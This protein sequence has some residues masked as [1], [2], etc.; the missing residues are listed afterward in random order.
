MHPVTTNRLLTQ[1][2]DTKTKS[3]F[4]SL[5][6]AERSGPAIW[7][8]ITRGK[9]PIITLESSQGAPPHSDRSETVKGHSGFS[10]TSV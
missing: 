10:I 3:A 4:F 7:Q 6:E 2:E 9:N 1:G 8:I 5:G